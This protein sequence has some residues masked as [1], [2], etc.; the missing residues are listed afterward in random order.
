MTI[1]P[2]GYFEARQQYPYDTARQGALAGENHGVV[3]LVPG[4][5][6]EQALQDLDGFSHIWLL[7]QFHHNPHWKPLTMPP[8]GKRKVGVFASRAPY[9]PNP[10][11]MS[12]VELAGIDGLRL[13]VR[14]HDLLDGTPILDIKPY[15]PYAD[16]VPHATCG[17]L[18]ELDDSPWRIAFESAAEQ[19][20][21]WLESRG[22]GCIRGFLLQQLA[23]QPLNGKKKRLRLLDGGSATWEI[24]YRTWRVRFAARSEER[25]IDI[26]RVYSGYNDRELHDSADPYGDKALHRAFQ[27]EFS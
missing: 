24:A 12:C 15:L 19:Q 4:C 22:A 27:T 9:R 25:A 6:Y 16:S 2:I 21:A 10:I 8:R 5:N 1:E 7:Y 11:G 13:E 20:L 23:E 14:Y 18:A 17:W 3:T 26:Q